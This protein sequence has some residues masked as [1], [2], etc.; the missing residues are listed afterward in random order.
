MV[1]FGQVTQKTI[2]VE[3]LKDD[4]D[5]LTIK[6]N[7]T[8]HRVEKVNY[9]DEGKEVTYVD[10]LRDTTCRVEDENKVYLGSFTHT[11]ADEN[12]NTRIDA[13]TVNSDKVLAAAKATAADLVATYPEE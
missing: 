1:K 12:A 8:Y 13:K 4:F 6:G 5:N 7:A 11:G 9:T 10:Q 2:K 3:V